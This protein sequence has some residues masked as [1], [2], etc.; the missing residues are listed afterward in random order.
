VPNYYTSLRQRNRRYL[1]M[2]HRTSRLRDRGKIEVTKQV[3]VPK[4]VYLNLHT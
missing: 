1:E 4:F 2:K 3:Y